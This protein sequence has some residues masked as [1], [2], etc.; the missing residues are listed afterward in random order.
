M[1]SQ[2]TYPDMVKQ[3]FKQLIQKTGLSLAELKAEYDV[4]FAKTGQIAERQFPK[5]SPE[6]RLSFRHKM[7]VGKLWNENVNRAPI[8]EVVII[9]L[10]HDGHRVTKG[11]KRPFNNMYVIVSEN[12]KRVLRRM[13]AR[14]SL[15]ETFMTLTPLT[16]Y[17]VELGRFAKGGDLIVDNRSIF[18]NPV[19]VDLPYKR[20][21]KILGIPEVTVKA[22]MKNLSK[23]EGN[24]TDST[25]WKCVVGY[26]SGDPFTFTNK[27]TGLLGGGINIADDTVTEEP[28][29][30]TR[31]NIVRAGLSGWA[32]PEHL[33]ADDGDLCAFYGTITEDNRVKGKP[34]MNILLI[35]PI[36]SSSMEDELWE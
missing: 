24:F 19:E 11:T 13:T 27:K 12:K 30:D 4:I 29:V 18:K 23:K 33:A 32:A 7:S 20:L 5:A 6:Q 34:V 35:I 1:S 10:G 9:F 14:G 17:T 26:V 28:T 2:V 22:A 21:N 15:A 3:R 25:D 36:M 8:E 31:G 16:K